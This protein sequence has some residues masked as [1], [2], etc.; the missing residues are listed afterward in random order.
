MLHEAN[1]FAVQIHWRS[2]HRRRPFLPARPVARTDTESWF[3]KT[4]S[5]V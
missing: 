4:D 3:V 2:R 1:D 5:D